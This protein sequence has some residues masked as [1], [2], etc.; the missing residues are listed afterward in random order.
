MWWLGEAIDEHCIADGCW[1]VAHTY[2]GDC[3]CSPRE[4]ISFIFGMMSIVAWAAAE[5]PQILHNY[6]CGT[7]EGVS[8]CFIATWVIGDMFNLTGCYISKTL[9]TQFYVALLY[10]ATTLILITQM[11]YYRHCKVYDEEDEVGGSVT[12]PLKAPLLPDATST[13]I[14]FNRPGGGRST[15]SSV[16]RQMGGR[17]RTSHDFAGSFVSPSYA[18]SFR[19]MYATSVH[20]SPPRLHALFLMVLVA[21]GIGGMHFHSQAAAGVS[22]DSMMLFSGEGSAWGV[23]SRRL[24]QDLN[25]TTA[26]EGMP[27]LAGDASALMAGLVAN[28]STVVEDELPLVGEPSSEPSSDDVSQLGLLMGWAMTALYLSGRLPQIM[29]NLNRGSVEGLS[30]SM[31]LFAITGNGTYTLSILVRSC[32]WTRIRPNLPWLVD[33]SMCLLMDFFIFGQWVHYRRKHRRNVGADQ[34]VLQ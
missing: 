30:I 20:N 24:L 13:A 32:E 23:G 3:V 8:L 7:S 25:A 21:G 5:I 11:L 29:H 16:P 18:S 33:S 34:V 9:P 1:A 12:G 2:F 17:G 22:T 27:A 31:F 28:A 26:E 14:P 19:T 10:T 15:A 6:Q 4:K